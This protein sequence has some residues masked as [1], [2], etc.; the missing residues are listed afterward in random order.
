MSDQMPAVLFNT[1]WLH[2]HEEDRPGETVFRPADYPLPPSRGRA[3]FELKQDGTLVRT[4]PG[5][6]DRRA[7]QTGTWSLNNDRLTLAAG[8]NEA[9]QVFRVKIVAPDR[10]VVQRES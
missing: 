2:S 4:Q 6:T 8:P 7:T 1:Q 9:P 5:P 3:G 10:L